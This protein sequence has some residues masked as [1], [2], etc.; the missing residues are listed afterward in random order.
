MKHSNEKTKSGLHSGRLKTFVITCV[1]VTLIAPNFAKAEIVIRSS[2]MS[3]QDFQALAMARGETTVSEALINENQRR[4]PP[5]TLDLYRQRLVDAQEEWVLR[6]TGEANLTPA[7]DRFLS[8]AY[9][10]DWSQSERKTFAT[11]FSRRFEM[12]NGD[13]QARRQMRAYTSDSTQE[14]ESLS[15]KRQNDWKEQ[16]AQDTLG[17]KTA[18]AL[19]PPLPSDITHVLVNGRTYDRAA[20]ADVKIPNQVQRITLVSN[21]YQPVSFLLKG[22]ETSW[23]E[24]Q[25]QAWSQDGCTPNPT[26]AAGF[27]MKV[28]VLTETACQET[29]AVTQNRAAAALAASSQT[30]NQQMLSKFGLD[31]SPKDSWPTAKPE[32]EKA[33]Y[34]KSWFWWS[35]AGVLAAGAVVVA[36]HQ[37]GGSTESV[38]PVTREGW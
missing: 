5:E 7:I 1:L 15:A 10:V 12:S 16:Q 20:F 38:R 18:A 17:W 11:F 6:T 29:E 30:S 26:R 27:D 4:I 23:P 3:E 24:L 14:L 33:F 13:E 37:R 34:E 31:R 19:Q 28:S 22:D 21:L 2:N 35:V 9:E 25:R 32:T 8:M 36:S